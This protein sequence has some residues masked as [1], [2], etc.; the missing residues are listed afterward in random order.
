MVTGAAGAVRFLSNDD[1]PESANRDASAALTDA[2][3][4]GDLRYPIA[5]RFGLEEIVEAHETAEQ[6]GAAERVVVSPHIGK[7]L[8]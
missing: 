1:F 6:L 5:K 3:R 4:A 8:S 7:D 2:L